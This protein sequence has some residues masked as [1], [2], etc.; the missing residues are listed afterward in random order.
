MVGAVVHTQLLAQDTTRVKRDSVRVRADSARVVADT[1]PPDS[2][3]VAAREATD[4]RLIAA[5]KAR[6]DTIKAPLARAENPPMVDIEPSFDYDRNTLFSTGALNLGELL[7]RIPGVT[8]FRAGWIASPHVAATLGEFGRVRVFQDGIE[9]DAM[10]PRTGGVLDVS[11]LD[12]WQMEGARVE[13]GANE[14]RVYLRSWRSRSVTPETRVDISTGDLETNAYR[15]YFSRRFKH[16]EALQLGAYQYSSQDPR[17]AGDASQ[18]SLF[19]RVGYAR[20]K[21]SVDGSFWRMSR[22]RS[23]QNARTPAP[24][25]PKL[26]ARYG[27]AYARIG[28]G[29]P[30]APGFWAQTIASTQSFD[31]SG[32]TPITI[33]DSIPGPG[34]GGPGG[35]PAVPDTIVISPDTS[36]SRPQYIGTAGWNIGLLRF[37]LTGRARNIEG[38]SKVSEVARAVFEHE[39]LS[40]SLYAERAPNEGLLR[41][42]LS[43]RI[44]PLPWISLGGAI[45]RYSA[46]GDADRPTTLAVRGEAGVRFGRLWATGGVMSRDTANLIAPIVFDKSFISV[47]Q[48]QTTGMFGT[49][50]GKVWRDVGVQFY[51]VRFGTAS[52]FRPQYQTR[53]ELFLNT[54]WPGKFPSGHLNILMAVTHEYRSHALFFQN[55]AQNDLVTLQSSGYRNWG[56]L[57]EIRL[58]QAT[59]TLQYRNFLG[60]QYSQVPGLEMPRVLS[61]YGVRWYFFN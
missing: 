51:G 26:D 32:G 19:G 34:G 1:L 20:K 33:I 25:L 46:I 54:S 40:A 2:A 43:G 57:L 47:S 49:L 50:N 52:A 17:N 12:M 42:E 48:G 10:D 23:E 22:D 58:L 4:R 16:G 44:Y 36:V 5:A 61:F 8:V 30:D 55:D 15:G 45:S 18:L 14:T 56:G 27:L 60:E 37:S 41:T 53:S 9:M 7:D 31:K 38:E 28:Y 11:T 21:F 35:S 29:D 59:L 3:S 39:R 13:R 6:A 24:N